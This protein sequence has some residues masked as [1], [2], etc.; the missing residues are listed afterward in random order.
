MTPLDKKRIKEYIKEQTGF[1]C[2]EILASFI[3]HPRRLFG[4]NN[5]ALKSIVE[6]YAPICKAFGFV[7]DGPREMEQIAMFE[8]TLSVRTSNK[9]DLQELLRAK[10][11][12]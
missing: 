4:L 8:M 1:A 3:L 2:S 7:L 12:Y 10:Y 6:E 11:K 5:K 9:P